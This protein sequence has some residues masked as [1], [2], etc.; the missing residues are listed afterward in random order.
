[1]E[2]QRFPEAHELIAGHFVR[3]S[4]AYYEWRIS[5][6]TAKSVDQR[7]P[8][9]FDDIAVAYD[10]LGQHDQAIE[11]IRAK[12]ARWPEERRYESEANLGT[13]HIHAGRF[14]EGL[15]HIDRAIE[16]NP[17]AHFG[18][19]VYQ[20]LLVEYVIESRRRDDQLPLD[21]EE[22]YGGTGFTAFVLAAQEAKAEDRLAEIQAAA[23]GI[24]G[25]MR[26][27]RH[28]SPILLEALG[29]LLLSDGFHE[30]SKML[31]ARAYLRASYEVD[32]SASSTAYRQK[33][34]RALE[35]QIGRKT[36]EIEAD[37]K[38]E[39]EQ[40]DAFFGQIA[41]DER[42]WIASGSDLDTEFAD[43]YYEAPELKVAHPN[44]KPMKPGTTLTLVVLGGLAI[45]FVASAS[46]LAIVVRSVRRRRA[47]SP[48]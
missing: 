21:D 7:T 10:K 28:D 30:D 37:L 3:H 14:E 22:S 25:M 39:M 23:E 34:R 46:I 2:R 19:E 44:W 15:Q 5:D 29:D 9:D 27:G 8:L 17:E 41:A 16:L 12:I 4:D 47:L 11:T 6:R 48:P 36:S 32:D 31:A 43:K 24:M 33:A 40:G 13:F 35:M 26:F 42:A 20:K 38:R 1:M 18:R 45:V